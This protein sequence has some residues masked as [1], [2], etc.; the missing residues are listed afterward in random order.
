LCQNFTKFHVH[1]RLNIESKLL[2][3]LSIL[4]RL[5]SIAH[6]VSGI[7]VAPDGKSKWSGIGF[8]RSSDSKRSS[9]KDFKLAMASRRAAL[10]GNTSLIATFSSH[11]SM[12]QRLVAVT[13]WLF[14]RD[15][16]HRIASLVVNYM[17][18]LHQAHGFTSWLRS[19][20][21]SAALQGQATRC[22]DTFSTVTVSLFIKHESQNQ[23][24]H[25][26]RI[27]V[28]QSVFRRHKFY[29]GESYFLSNALLLRR[30]RIDS[31]VL[32]V[33]AHTVYCPFEP[34]RA[35]RPK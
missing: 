24:T 15:G 5:H 3:T 29:V 25:P 35:V 17:Y 30:L 10:S 32:C 4:F 12:L 1:K 34:T 19:P 14:M 7:N 20:P 27:T 6:A 13:V 28:V 31:K 33:Q 9:L 21:P 2:P 22:S 18:A 16:R 8:V 23:P 11:L 26:A